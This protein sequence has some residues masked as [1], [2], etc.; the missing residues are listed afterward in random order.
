MML[1]MHGGPGLGTPSGGDGWLSFTVIMAVLAGAVGPYVWLTRCAVRGWTAWRTVA[2]LAGCSM[3]G[4]AMSPVLAGRGDPVAHMAQHLLLGMLA[5]L[6]LG[7]AD[8]AGVAVVRPP[9]R[10]LAARILQSPLVHVVGHPVSAVV[11]QC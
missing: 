2:W 10:R 3:V 9:V 5:P 6:G 4:V 1:S 7:C 8:D 11:R